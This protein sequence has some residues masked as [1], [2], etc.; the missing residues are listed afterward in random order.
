MF[1][2]FKDE[3]KLNVKPK[4]KGTKR[5]NIFFS[6]NEKEGISIKKFTGINCH[7]IAPKNGTAIKLNK[8]YVKKKTRY[9]K[10]SLFKKAGRKK[11]TETTIEKIRNQKGR[12]LSKPSSLTT[13]AIFEETITSPNLVPMSWNIIENLPTTFNKK[14]LIISKEEK[15]STV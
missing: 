11:E 13:R 3:Y 10:F 15:A 9:F 14:N 8:K 4:N 5:E 2:S 12:V 6:R 7:G 1:S